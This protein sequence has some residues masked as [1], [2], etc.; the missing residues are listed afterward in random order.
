M[1][2]ISIYFLNLSDVMLLTVMTHVWNYSVFL[3]HDVKEIQSPLNTL[4][5]STCAE[6][7]IQ[8]SVTERYLLY[9]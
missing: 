5:S 8:Y 9:E 6:V 4:I 7:R 3:S 1:V 2:Y